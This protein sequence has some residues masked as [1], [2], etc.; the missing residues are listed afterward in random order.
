MYL[1]FSAH[2]VVSQARVLLLVL[3]AVPLVQLA[4]SAHRARLATPTLARLAPIQ[5]SVFSL[6][7]RG[8]NS[9]CS[10]GRCQRLYKLRARDVFAFGCK[11]LPM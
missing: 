7:A 1:Q 9:F 4:T 3:L 6:C 2:L 10:A 8:F 11:R 5:R